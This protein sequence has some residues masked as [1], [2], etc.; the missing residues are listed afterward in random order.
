MRRRRSA[1][2]FEP[3]LIK[4]ASEDISPEEAAKLQAQLAF[5][6]NIVLTKLSQQVSDNADA[7]DT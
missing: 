3:I 2:E 1:R 5:E 6:L 4:L 7:I